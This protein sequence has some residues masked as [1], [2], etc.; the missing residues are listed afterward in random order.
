MNR[1]FTLFL[2][3]VAAGLLGFIFIVAPHQTSTRDREVT[4]GYLLDFSMPDVRSVEIYNGN[5]LIEIERDAAVWRIIRPLH[6]FAEDRQISLLLQ[7]A[8]NLRALDRITPRQMKERNLQLQ[9][10]GL[11]KPKQRIDF[12][13]DGFEEIQF[14]KEA[15]GED[16][17]YARQLKSDDLFV[18]KADLQKTAF[19][20]V[21]AFRQLRLTRLIPDQLASV[22]I[23]RDGGQIDLERDGLQWKI[24]RPLQAAADTTAVGELL[25]P[26][27]AA[28]IKEFVADSRDASG[29]Y[30]LVEPRATIRMTPLRDTESVTMVIGADAPEGDL[31]Y[32]TMSDRDGVFGIPSS[33][34]EKLGTTVDALRARDLYRVNPDI[35]DRILIE[36]EGMS[37][38]L[39]R[40]GD[41]WVPAGSGP[42]VPVI[43]QSVMDRFM[44]DIGQT[45]VESFEQILPDDFARFGLKEPVA[46]LRLSAWLSENTPE[47]TRGGEA[48]IT[49]DFGPERDGLVPAR[50]NDESEV[51]L[52]PATIL[53]RLTTDADA[54]RSRATPE[55]I[56]VSPVEE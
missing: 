6:D 55:G 31:V 40:R 35:V 28:P 30:G 45:E 37:L 2:I 54:L 52:L 39:E 13:G 23:E 47:A 33:S 1:G 17:V 20:D 27:L 50:I 18:V 51:A 21:D 38:Q 5:E 10:F 46:R 49:V 16:V 22:R 56:S 12:K 4:E 53:D 19:Q 15:A 34:L 36:R 48:I 7:R 3:L 14:G 42:D 8:Q 43:P 24:A 25:T 9:D 44:R 32:A 29:A 26:L 41:D 11:E